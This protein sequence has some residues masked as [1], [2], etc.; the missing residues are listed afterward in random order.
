TLWLNRFTPPLGAYPV[1][2]DSIQINW[3]NQPGILGKQ[4]RLLVYLDADGDNNPS[5]A[6]LLLQQVVSID[7]LAGWQNYPISLAI[8][9]PTGSG[10]IY[11]GFEDA[12]AEG[13]YT[14]MLLPAAQDSTPPSQVRSWMIN[15]YNAAPFL[16]DLG[17]NYQIGIIDTLNPPLAGNWMIR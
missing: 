7:I 4:A 15:N 1:S 6:T 3:P 12:W 14:P 9:S 17:A 13:G 2:L 5:N 8:D 10:D 16:D 11:I